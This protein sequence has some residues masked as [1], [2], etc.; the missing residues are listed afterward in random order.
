MPKKKKKGKKEK[1][2]KKAKPDKKE[3]KEKKDNKKAKKDKSEKRN[4]S[5]IKEEPENRSQA[6]LTQSTLL[7]TKNFD[8]YRTT[9]D[10]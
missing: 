5:P 4:I 9:I 3:K 1:P 7:R 6:N 8:S 2:A 10:Y